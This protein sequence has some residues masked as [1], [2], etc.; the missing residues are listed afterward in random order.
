MAVTVNY[1]YPGLGLGTNPPS[2]AQIALLS[3]VTAQVVFGDADTTAAITHNFGISTPNLGS[4]FPFVGYYPT[5]LG[6][7]PAAA[8]VSAALTNSNVV[9]LTKSATTAGTNGTYNVILLRPNSL[10]T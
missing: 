10:I 5:L 4:L 2:I 1:E 8:V 6:T 7:N 9:T 3:A